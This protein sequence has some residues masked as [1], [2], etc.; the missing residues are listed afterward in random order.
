MINNAIR[1]AQHKLAHHKEKGRN[2][3]L[4]IT[5]VA[6]LMDLVTFGPVNHQLPNNMIFFSYNVN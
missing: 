5:E 1:L 2:T 3:N 6:Q 4:S